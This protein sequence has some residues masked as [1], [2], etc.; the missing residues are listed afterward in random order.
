MVQ[1]FEGFFLI[2]RGERDRGQMIL[3]VMQTIALG[4]IYKLCE[5]GVQR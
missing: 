5:R 4:Y 3:E 1:G 2:K